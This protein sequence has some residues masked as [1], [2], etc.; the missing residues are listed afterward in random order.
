MLT[1]RIPRCSRRENG[2]ALLLVLTTLPA[3]SLLGA[4]LLHNATLDGDRTLAQERAVQSLYSAEG[5]LA[6]ARWALEATGRLEDVARQLPAG[7]T[8]ANATQGGVSTGLFAWSGAITLSATGSSGL[9]SRTVG[10]QI[11]PDPPATVDFKHVITSPGAI[12]I[13]SCVFPNASWVEGDILTATECDLT[14]V[15]GIHPV[16]TAGVG[17]V[18]VEAAIAAIRAAVIEIPVTSAEIEASSPGDPYV[19]DGSASTAVYWTNDPGLTLSNG[20]STKQITILGEVLWLVEDGWW[21][22]KELQLAGSGPDPRLY[23]LAS[24]N[25]TNGKGFDA[26]KQMQTSGGL[27]LLLIT[28]G[29]LDFRKQCTLGN[30]AMFGARVGAECG[31]YFVYDPATMD[32]WIDSIASRGWL[33]LPGG[34]SGSLAIVSGSWICD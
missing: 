14:D 30:V 2:S 20:G 15:L 12:D 22:G 33:P 9:S 13:K 6:R 8:A 4:S 16:T 1:R 19:M 23:I 17:T 7:V 25:P 10:Q 27:A 28:D 29:D 3:L 5:G 11:E 18:D 32:P 34:G 24:K 31:E 26:Q 21:V